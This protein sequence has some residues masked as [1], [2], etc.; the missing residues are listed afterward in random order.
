MSTNTSQN[1]S[2]TTFYREFNVI[3]LYFKYEYI[4]TDTIADIFGSW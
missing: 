2:K 3:V 1:I 4:I